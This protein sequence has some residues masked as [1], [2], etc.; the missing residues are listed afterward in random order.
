MQ[1]PGYEMAQDLVVI[2]PDGTFAAFALVW[3][4]PRSKTGQFEPVGTAPAF[5]RLGLGQ[6]VLLKGLQLMQKQ[7]LECAFV[8][9]EG[10]DTPA[11]QLY[12]SVGLSPQWDLYLYSR[13]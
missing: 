6:T 2:A 1:S 12:H 9:V 10:A 8:I 7:R 3:I 13:A 5:R 4:D 11:V